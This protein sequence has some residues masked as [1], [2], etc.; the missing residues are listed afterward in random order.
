MIS[1]YSYAIDVLRKIEYKLNN[2]Y[3]FRKLINNLEKKKSNTIR[4][5]WLSLYKYINLECYKPKC[6]NFELVTNCKMCEKRYKWN[7]YKEIK[8][9]SLDNYSKASKYYLYIN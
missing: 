5:K 6:S 7:F 1:N 9:Y 8:N 2:Q 4:K 3:Y